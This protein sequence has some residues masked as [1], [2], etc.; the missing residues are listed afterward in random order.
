MNDNNQYLCELYDAS[1]KYNIRSLR[2]TTEKYKILIQCFN[3]S[4]VKD[5]GPLYTIEEIKIYRV[6]E[7]NSE[8]FSDKNNNNLVL[9]HGTSFNNSAGILKNGFR[10]SQRGYYGQGVYLTECTDL[11]IHYSRRQNN[12]S[13]SN[14]KNY[15]FMNEVFN[16][17]DLKTPVFPI[18]TNVSSTSPLTHSLIKYEFK[19]SL[20][21]SKKHYIFDSNG[22]KY[23]S[24]PVNIWS[25]MDE[26]V[27]AADSLKPR[28]LFE[29]KSNIIQCRW[30]NFTNFVK[31]WIL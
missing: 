26:Y 29:F 20:N 2:S 28:Y 1:K 31:K 10:I 30:N 19:R 11:A 23:R 14:E 6:R 9:Y 22:L 5:Y 15:V 17:N 16:K 27:T 7:T 24:S 4:I 3:S 12:I 8:N 13:G 18:S 25:S 21:K